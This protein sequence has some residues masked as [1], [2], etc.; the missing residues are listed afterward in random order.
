MLT[1]IYG[2]AFVTQ[3][4][5]RRAPRAARAGPRA[6]PPQARPRARPVHVLRA[7]A[8]LAVL[9]A[10]RHGD[11]ERADRAVARART[12]RAATARCRRRSSTTSSCGSS[13][14]HWDKY[15]DNMYF[16]DVEGRADGPQADE[17]PGAHPDLQ[18]TSG[19]P[20]A[21]C[22]SATPSRASCT[23]TSRAARCTACCA[24]ATSPR[25]T[26]TSSAPRSRSRRRS[27]ALPRLRLRHLRPLRLR[28]AARAL[29]PA[30]EAHRRPTR[31]GTAPRR[32]SQAAL[33]DRGLDVR[34]QR[35][36]R[37]VL[38]AEDRP[39]T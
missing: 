39:R 32:R 12:S 8:R 9:A 18:A 35:G 11:L 15:R 20:T 1:R 10:Q 36:R 16:T 14:G 31:C 26:R 23:A 37:R 24:C 33:D 21:T 38:R 19:A 25:T 34:A 6:R 17:L 28:A 2:T 22:R 29:D 13:S 30:R 5:A 27:S 4:G 3:G 7:L